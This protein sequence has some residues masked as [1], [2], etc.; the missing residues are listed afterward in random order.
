M[1]ARVEHVSRRYKDF[2]FVYV[3]LDGQHVLYQMKNAVC[4]C[5][6]QSVHLIRPSGN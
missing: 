2:S 5:N 4:F 3:I 6:F 1:S